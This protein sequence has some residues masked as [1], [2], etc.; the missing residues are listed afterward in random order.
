MMFTLE[1]RQL[2]NSAHAF[3][4]FS[5]SGSS[6]A[7]DLRSTWNRGV[8]QLCGRAFESAAAALIRS[9]NR[10]ADPHKTARCI[11][12]LLSM[13]AHLQKELERHQEHLL[14]LP[15]RTVDE[16]IILTRAIMYLEEA[17]KLLDATCAHSI[18]QL[19]AL[20]TDESDYLPS[21]LTATQLRTGFPDAEILQLDAHHAVVAFGDVSTTSSITT[22]VAGV[23]SS[24]PTTWSDSF[25]TAKRISQVTGGAAVA[26]LG[27]SAPANLPA[28]IATA[29]ASRGAQELK[30]FQSSLRLRNPRAK[31]LALGH[32]YGS[33]VAG[34]AAATGLDADTLIFA[35]S[36]GVS[37]E[38][39]LNS[40]SPRVISA[41]GSLDPIGLTGTKYT[42]LHGKDPTA[43]GFPAEQWGIPGGHSSYVTSPLFLTR[44]AEEAR[45]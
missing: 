13:T 2:R 15:Q 20:C 25:Y 43:A 32:S 24:D 16:S 6:A 31:L 38:I 23:T 14:L 22:L 41:L 28:A 37:P 42:A 12:R 11:A 35:G 29:P 4:A 44:L 34:K 18:T 26:W 27:Y 1:S 39:N 33:V 8:E 36:P 7:H 40:D 17:G 5:S 30:D 3:S 19:S 45:R 10:W 9:L 21:T